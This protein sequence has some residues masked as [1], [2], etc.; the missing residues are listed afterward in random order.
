MLVWQ[1]DK[2]AASCLHERLHIW[3]VR[4]IERRSLEMYKGNSKEFP[5]TQRGDDNDP[6]IKKK[7]SPHLARVVQRVYN[8]ND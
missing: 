4:Y 2:N 1:R 7:Y 3:R 8:D 6:Q 5:G